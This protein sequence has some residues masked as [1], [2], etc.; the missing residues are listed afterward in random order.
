MSTSTL[1]NSFPVTDLGE[2]KY[3]VLNWV[4][5]FNTFCFLDNHQ[6]HIEPH[7]QECIVGAGI[8][9]KVIATGND[10]LDLLQKF[11]DEKRTW[12]FGHLAYDLSIEPGELLSRHKDR[13]QFPDLFFFEPEIIIRLNGKEMIIEASDPHQIFDEISSAPDRRVQL[14]SSPLIQSRIQKEE[15]ISIIREL[16]NHILRGDCYEINFCQEFYAE[17]AIIDPGAIYKK[18]TALSPNPFSALYRVDDRWLMCASPERFLKREGSRILSQPIK[19]TSKRIGDNKVEDEKNREELFHSDKDRSE[20]VMV[21]DLVR[22]DLSKVCKEGTVKVEELYG[23]YSFPQV[24]QMI[25][26]VSGE[27]RKNVSFAEI[28]KATFPMGSMTGAPKKRVMELIEEYEKTKRGIFSGCLGY[29][30]PNGD[31]DLNVV[32]RSLMY[33]AFS[34]YLS[35]QAGSAITFYSD[36]EKEW[37]ECLLKAEAIKTVLS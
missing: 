33:N 35:F 32:I 26:T 23:I 13:I 7:T 5:R 4:Q 1:T 31:F 28:V 16:Q 17:K 14:Q 36:P 20:N 21:V 11:T 2:I 34:N 3:K 37:D 27:L 18:L 15:Y 9:R 25:S 30:S 10:A 24:H 19:G 12:L 8:K 6:Y 29:I 22:N